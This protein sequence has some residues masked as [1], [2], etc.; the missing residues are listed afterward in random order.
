MILDRLNYVL[1]NPALNFSI[2]AYTY[3]SSRD[4]KF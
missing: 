3:K 2:Y 1:N 4:N